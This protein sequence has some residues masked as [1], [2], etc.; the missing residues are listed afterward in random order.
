MDTKKGWKGGTMLF[1][2]N[3]FPF[4]NNNIQKIISEMKPEEIDQYV[5]DL[6]KKAFQDNFNGMGNP[7]NLFKGFSPIN[8]PNSNENDHHS[9]SKIQSSVFETH[10]YVYARIPIKNEEWLQQ[11][12]LFHTSN[13]LI[14]EHIPELDDRHTITL[15]AIVK[16]KGS[17]AQFKEGVLEV[18]IPKNVDMQYSEIDVKEI[19]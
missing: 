16:R 17:T 10:D 13:Q 12:R 9:S 1:P 8:N 19:Y 14:I 2:W 5:K 11:L 18:K 4:H 3:L 6:M 15:P 7:E